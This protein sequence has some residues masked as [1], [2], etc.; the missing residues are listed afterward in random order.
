MSTLYASQQRP[1]VSTNNARTIIMAA[2]EVYTGLWESTLG[3]NVVLV[4]ISADADSKEGGIRVEFHTASTPPTAGVASCTTYT[5]DT[6]KRGTGYA[7]AFAA[8]G[9][10]FRIE[11]LNGAAAHASAPSV[12]CV[13][14]TVY[15]QAAPACG[16][17]E[18]GDAAYDAFRRLRVSSM[19]TLLSISHNHSKNDWLVDEKTTDGAST[20]VSAHDPNTSCIDMSIVNNSS[21]ASVVRQSRKYC[22]YQP[23]KSLLWMGTAVL[24]LSSNTAHCATRTGLFDDSNGVFFEHSAGVLRVVKRSKVSGAV[25]DTSVDKTNFNVDQLDGKGPSQFALDA[26]KANIFWIDMQW[27]GVGRVRFG[28]VCDGRLVVC[29]TMNHENSATAPYMSRASL[30]V[31]YEVRAAGASP[32]TGG[33]RMICSTVSSEGGYETIGLPA[34]A[35]RFHN[36]PVSVTDNKTCVVA[37]RLRSTHVRARVAV[38]GFRLMS[39]TAGDFVCAV[40]HWRQPTSDPLTNPANWTA[41]HPDSAVEYSLGT[42][43]DFSAGV[44]RQHGFMTSSTDVVAGTGPDQQIEL[45]AGIDGTSDVVAVMCQRA[46]GTAAQNIFG[47]INWTEFSS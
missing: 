25:T 41:H 36:A 34:S 15:A 31:R 39:T 13:L 42:I 47:C 29:H 20:L 18:F 22:E 44:V 40:Y 7:R 17:V 33:I 6:Y 12:V 37:I 4:V 23:G 5:L 21:T 9:P 10:Y 26:A 28:T 27:L 35:G 16:Q 24:N 30:P 14:D 3:Y 11:Y 38:Q 2:N 1:R 43:A 19:H 45:L 8:Q 32:A 46:T